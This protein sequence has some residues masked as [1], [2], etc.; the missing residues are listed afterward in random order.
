MRLPVEPLIENLPLEFQHNHKVAIAT[1]QRTGLTIY[2][3]DRMCLRYGVH[4]FAVYGT[5]WY[6]DMWAEVA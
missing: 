4:P 1:W 5:K 3:A 6:S 2:E